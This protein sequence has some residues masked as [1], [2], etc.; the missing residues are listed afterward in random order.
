MPLA[1]TA[2]AAGCPL[3]CGG[4]PVKPFTPIGDGMLGT[5][6]AVMPGGVLPPENGDGGTQGQS[7]WEL[8]T[9]TPWRKLLVQELR[10][11]PAKKNNPKKTT[12]NE[13]LPSCW[14]RLLAIAPLFRKH[15]R[16]AWKASKN[17]QPQFSTAAPIRFPLDLCGCTDFQDCSVCTLSWIHLSCANS[18]WTFSALGILKRLVKFICSLKVA[19]DTFLMSL[20]GPNL[21]SYSFNN[22]SQ[23]R[24]V[25]FGLDLFL[26]WNRILSL[27][28]DASC[29]VL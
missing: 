18:F 13:K 24:G 22:I 15:S 27:F 8:E 21:T 7:W 2:S 20:F 1:N 29:G 10:P 25:K 5:A 14:A 17:S 9:A 6:G 3:A 28:P 23:W 12:R 26:S 16:K 19:T 11:P 4:R